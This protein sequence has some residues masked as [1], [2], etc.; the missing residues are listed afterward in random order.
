VPDTCPWRRRR[1]F[2]AKQRPTIQ[3]LYTSTLLTLVVLPSV[4]QW[5]ASERRDI[6]V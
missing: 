1:E 3:G 5:F 2:C 6:S 4:Y